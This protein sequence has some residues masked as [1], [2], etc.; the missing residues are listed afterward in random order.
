[1]SRIPNTTGPNN[2]D[3][4]ASKSWL[5]L[6]PDGYDIA[7]KSWLTLSTNS[8]DID[9]KSR[10]TLSTNSGDLASK[11]W[12]TLS[13]NSDDIASKSWLTLSPNGDDIASKSWLTLSLD[14]DDIAC[15]CSCLLDSLLLIGG[16]FGSRLLQVTSTT[17][18]RTRTLSL[19]TALPAPVL[20]GPTALR[21]EKKPHLTDEKEEKNLKMDN[22]Y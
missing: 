13:T 1:M 22:F 14:G 7:S 10:L 12:L 9:S 8:G 18:R 4:I 6:S 17:S 2:G 5:T 15:C 16:S 19:G 21:L 11:S 20:A 3:I